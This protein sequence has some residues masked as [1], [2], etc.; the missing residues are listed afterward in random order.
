MFQTLR[1]ESLR[2][3]CVRPLPVVPE[4][5]LLAEGEATIGAR[6]GLIVEVNCPVHFEFV[7]HAKCLGAYVADVRLFTS[8]QVRVMC[9]LC[10]ESVLGIAART[11]KRK[12]V[13]VC[14]TVN[15]KRGTL[16]EAFPALGAD[17][18]ALARVYSHVLRHVLAGGELD[19]ADGARVV[20]DLLV[21]LAHVSP[22]PGRDAE[23]LAAQVANARLL[24]RVDALV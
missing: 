4:I 18:G 11:R 12:M 14:F 17:V 8:V 19:G 5:P 20:L 3:A 16:L 10:P 21:G 9:Q 2:R 6:E 1:H 22:Q 15:V 7:A 23:L 24:A 13:R